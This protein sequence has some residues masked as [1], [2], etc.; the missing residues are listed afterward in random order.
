MVAQR[1]GAAAVVV[2]M[3]VDGAPNTATFI[4][5]MSLWVDEITA[6]FAAHAAV[7]GRP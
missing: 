2:P 4:E 5:M 6:G 1:T 3:N 7:T